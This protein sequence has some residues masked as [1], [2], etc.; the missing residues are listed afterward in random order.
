MP[1]ADLCEESA[2]QLSAASD[3]DNLSRFLS[4]LTIL[5]A[6]CRIGIAGKPNLYVMEAEDFWFSWYCDDEGKLVLR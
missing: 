4:G 5:A 2:L 3:S 1:T 6:E